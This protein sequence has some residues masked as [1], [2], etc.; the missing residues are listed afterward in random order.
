MCEGQHSLQ[1]FI[2]PTRGCPHHRHNKPHHTITP[3]HNHTISQSH[4][5]TVSQSHQGRNIIP[6]HTT[7]LL[8]LLR[9]SQHHISSLKITK[10]DITNRNSSQEITTNDITNRNS[11]QKT[12]ITTTPFI[13]Y[14]TIHF[15]THKTSHH[16]T[17]H[18]Q[19]HITN[20]HS[21]HL[22]TSPLIRQKTQHIPPDVEG[23]NDDMATEPA[24]LPIQYGHYIR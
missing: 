16:N 9:T 18:S 3:Y 14:L 4:T 10:N 15:T 8:P 24:T 5:H 7:P 20:R 12:T 19:H 1:K 23:N 21:S 11:S 22:E 6:Y 2:L 17:H 13:K